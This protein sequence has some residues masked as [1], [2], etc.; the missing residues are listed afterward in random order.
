MKIIKYSGEVFGAKSSLD[1]MDFDKIDRRKWKEL[2]EMWKALKL[3]MRSYK[4]R[5]PNML[6][7]LSEVAF[8]LFSGSKRLIALRSK[9]A[10]S[11]SFDTYNMKKN[12]AE[13]IKASSVLSDLTSFGPKSKWDD[14]YFLDFYNQGK[15]NGTFNVYLIPNDLIFLQKV[16]ATQTFIDQQKQGKRPRFSLVDKIIVPNDLKPIATDVKVW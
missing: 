3:G 9:V 15:L 6:E 5:E 12:R 16:N 11:S 7:G 1:L 4:A 13:Q 8:C 14:L 10:I 2:F